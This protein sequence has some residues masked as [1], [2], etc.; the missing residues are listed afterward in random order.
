MPRPL[1]IRRLPFAGSRSSPMKHNLRRKTASR[2]K[3]RSPGDAETLWRLLDF[4]PISLWLEDW[5]SAKAMLD[6]WKRA[7]IADPVAHAAADR[8]RLAALAETI[9]VI[10]A[11][12]TSVAMYGAPDRES[13]IADYDRQKERLLTGDM[14]ELFLD[15][16]GGFARGERE[17]SA[18][19]WDSAFDGHAMRTRVSCSIAPGDLAWDQVTMAIEDITE[20]WQTRAALEQSQALLAQAAK[21]AGLAHW[22]WDP[23]LCTMIDCTE[24]IEQITGRTVE[25]WR[26]R[27]GED[28]GLSCIAPA[29]RG[30]YMNTVPPA[31]ATGKPY[32]L[33]YRLLH[34]DG[35][36]RWVRESGAPLPPAPGA[37]TARCIGV[38]QD[39]TAMRAAEAAHRD[40]EAV[41]QGFL[42]NAPFNMLVKDL[43][44][45]YRYA[46]EALASL[47]GVPVEALIGKR[48]EDFFVPETAAS[49]RAQDDQVVATLAPV[50]GEVRTLH[51]VGP[52][53]EQ[54]IRFPII[55]AEGRLS[56]IGS[57][58]FNIDDRKRAEEAL[59]ESEAR[60]RAFFENADTE[61]VLKDAEGRYRLVSRGFERRLG[62]TNAAIKGKTALEVFPK[63][64]VDV[65]TVDEHQVIATR[66]PQPHASIFEKNG[67]RIHLLGTRFPL[68][69]ARG[70][71]TGTGLVMTDVSELSRMEREL[72]E[73]HDFLSLMLDSAGALITV[74][75]AQGRMIR[76]NRA[77]EAFSGRTIQEL[78]RD[79]GWLQSIPE[80]DREGVKQA[81][82]A[83]EDAQFPNVRLN[84]WIRH[85]GENRLIEWTNAALR[86]PD[87][88]IRCVVCIGTDIS[89]RARIERQLAEQHDF[90]RVV[91]D[92]AAVFITVHELNGRMV[93]C[94]KAFEEFS[95]LNFDQMNREGGWARTVLPE[96]RAVVSA[97]LSNADPKR[98][99]NTDL[100]RGIRADGEVRLI[101]WRN[102]AFT[103]PDGGIKYIVCI[104]ADITEQHRTETALRESETRL[105][106]FLDNAPFEIAL[107]QRDGRYLVANK[108]LAK[109]FGVQ[110]E[111]LV[112]R[113]VEAFVSASFC[114]L[115]TAMD[116]IVLD[117]GETT[118]REIE[119]QR[120]SGTEWIQELKFPIRDQSGAITGIGA[121]GVDITQRKRD[122]Q[123]RR[124]SEAQLKAFLEYAPFEVAIKDSEGRFLMANQHIASLVGAPVGA[125][126][127][128]RIAELMPDGSGHPYASH[129]RAVLEADRPITRL[130]H[131]KG[132]DGDH[133]SQDTKFPIR[134]AEG[135]LFGIG[136][137]GINVTERVKIENDLREKEERWQAFKD[138][139]PFC[140]VIKTP[141]GRYIDVNRGAER[142][143]KNDTKEIVGHRVSDI[144]VWGMASGIANED[145]QVLQ[146]GQAVAREFH[147]EGSSEG[148]WLR[149]LKFPIRD[150]QGHITAIGG[151]CIDITDLKKAEAALMQSKADLRAVL[152]GILEGI[153]T[154]D[155]DGEIHSFSPAASRMLG[156]ND[157]E[158]AGRPLGLLIPE[159]AVADQT[160]T[161]FL[162]EIGPRLGKSRE[163]GAVAKDG[164]KLP[165][166][167]SANELPA[168]DGTRRFVGT[169]LDLT[170]H[171]ALEEQLRQAQKMESIGQFTG[172]IAHDFNNLLAVIV[173]N[174]DLVSERA[175]SDERLRSL[176]ARASNAAQR[177][178]DLTRRLLAFARRQSLQPIPVDAGKLVRE[179]IPLLNRSVGAEIEVAA[180]IEDRLR[181]ALVDPGQLEAAL[182]NLIGN[183]RDAMPDGGRIVIRLTNN[184]HVEGA[185]VAHL[186]LPA[187]HYVRIAVE[188]TG[189][190]MPPEVLERAFEPFFTTKDVGRGTGLGLSMVHGFAHQSGGDVAI[191]SELGKGTTISL[192]LPA[193]DQP[194]AALDR[195]AED[196]PPAPGEAAGEAVRILVVD[197]DLDMLTVARDLLAMLG[198]T[199]E[200]VSSGAEAL[201][202]LRQGGIY[203]LLLTD[204]RMKGGMSGPQL[205]REAKQVA[206]ALKLLF[207]S[208]YEDAAGPIG[209]IPAG[210]ILLRKPFR[211]EDLV[212][213]IRAALNA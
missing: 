200:A 90:L 182:L 187:G 65:V 186:T 36:E 137:I 155:E 198:Y 177:G 201:E 20:A 169:L 107:K 86:N 55:D 59:Q 32:A 115:L 24:Q 103:S 51:P 7:G 79:D 133:W 191:E 213:G 41:L 152:D 1:K 126:P 145:H 92:C 13:L 208:G 30:L 144:D 120:A 33:E 185:D 146:S 163:I 39:I 199:V 67:N 172:G 162:A 189:A 21:L 60:L 109:A 3:T 72:R 178:A 4:A 147:V 106:A 45:R 5:S 85:D 104:G 150:Q 78:E 183:A 96:D 207:M 64:L 167:F 69:D 114:E 94:N 61:M 93:R 87:G 102:A 16:L 121:I 184:V 11:N 88:S 58:G 154:F 159:L 63:D 139:A 173:G 190:G 151:I 113:R 153:V 193:T 204:V 157:T 68:L 125:L 54:Q 127:G 34:P 17:V 108:N 100:A 31:I 181:R 10:D 194:A 116:R 130:I 211:H 202:R 161:D 46:N 44:R 82:S 131:T 149:H 168:T 111:D 192:F 203:D 164:R 141:D 197:D 19:T 15:I 18:E 2:T 73:Q 136:C 118:I 53:W 9:R 160:E 105:Q 43:D 27:L 123:A 70:E 124:E 62:V 47:V 195:G 29:D 156:Y 174:L 22:I 50:T 25:E 175:A 26:V 138:H 84:R 135:A 76:C 52:I 95:G 101:Q 132:P 6:A 23:T 14:R 209:S 170:E 37:E 129:D 112:G 12:A 143:W 205:A 56:G 71:L 77:V 196:G 117:T 28:G 140:I 110:V 98:F 74:H 35:T 165:V 122:E 212:R 40:T 134:D 128:R 8:H 81:V 42:R 38:L 89:E 179:L 158:L 206:P 171:K 66:Q 91:I 57:I 119:A 188:D 210:A 176:V 97:I 142:F 49:Y 180:E 83:L 99:P 148:E 75:D 80:A 166:A 48:A